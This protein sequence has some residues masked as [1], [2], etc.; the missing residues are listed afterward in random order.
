MPFGENSRWKTAMAGN[1]L[2]LI[3]FTFHLLSE[4]VTP[5]VY[6]RDKKSKYD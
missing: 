3:A 2:S 4:L 1:N 6:H 5:Y